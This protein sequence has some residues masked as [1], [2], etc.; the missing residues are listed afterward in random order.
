MSIRTIGMFVGISS[1]LAV[2]GCGSDSGGGASTGGTSGGLGGDGGAPNGGSG[3]TS[4]AGNSG[5]GASGGSAGSGGSTVGGSGAGGDGAGGS[6]AGGSGATAGLSGKYP[7]DVGIENDAD[8]IFHSDF[9]SEMDGW[10]SY[11]Q[12]AERLRVVDD[13]SLAN[14]GSKFL[15]ANVTRT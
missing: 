4:G 11:T 9:E 7:G 15:E 12:N 13:A 8:V 10:T 5:N 14:A 1:F 6:G 2:I 3:A